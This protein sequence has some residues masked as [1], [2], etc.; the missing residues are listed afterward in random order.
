MVVERS[1]LNL[2]TTEKPQT[3]VEENVVNRVEAE[4]TRIIKNIEQREM[5]P[6]P[7]EK[8]NQGTSTSRFRRIRTQ[9]KLLMGLLRSRSNF[10]R[11]KRCTELEKET[12]KSFLT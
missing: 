4:K 5:K 8:I 3:I 9:T 1:S 12:Q 6:V 7:Q 2:L 10:H 11:C